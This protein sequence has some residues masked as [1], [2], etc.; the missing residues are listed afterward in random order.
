MMKLDGWTHS[1]WGESNCHLTAFKS[2]KLSGT[3][4]YSSSIPQLFAFSLLFCSPTG[5]TFLLTASLK[6]WPEN[7]CSPPPLFIFFLENFGWHFH[8]TSIKRVNYLLQSFGAD[9]SAACLPGA[10]AEPSAILLLFQGSET[11]AAC[12]RESNKNCRKVPSQR[13]CDLL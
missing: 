5:T 12:S 6:L 9:Q 10:T 8:H 2:L 1:F 11:K 7:W 13:L 3:L 4:C